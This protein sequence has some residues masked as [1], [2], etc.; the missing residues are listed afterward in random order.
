MQNRTAKLEFKG[1]AD[2]E[3]DSLVASFNKEPLKIYVFCR[4]TPFG[5][6]K[7]GSEVFLYGVSEIDL[8]LLLMNGS[9]ETGTDNERVKTISGWYHIYDPDDHYRTLGQMKVYSPVE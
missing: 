3:L 8:S 9:F 4:N 1:E 2:L 5:I 7:G 6:A